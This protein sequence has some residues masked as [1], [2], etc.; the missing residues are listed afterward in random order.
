MTAAGDN[1]EER[2]A[3]EAE[4]EQKKLDIQKKYADTEMVINIAKTIAAGAL[5]IVQGFAQL[6]PVAGAVAAAIIGV[7]TAAE[8]ATIIAQRNAIKN[9][10]AGGGGG[11]APKTGSREMTGYAEGG[12]TED[13]TTVTTVGERGREW[14][15]PAWMVRKNPVT[16]SN[17]ERYRK[18]GSHGRS[19]S[20]SRGFADGGFT[21]NV[22]EKMQGGMLSVGD[23]EAA[24]ETAI[25]KSMQNGAIRAY[26]VRNDLTELDS[27]TER[28]KKMTSR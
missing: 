13:H 3:I 8:I 16:F 18:T 5:A 11:S 14:V 9:A 12:Y 25:V 10:S 7:T 27:Q 28:F 15:A 26:L 23:L 20:V 1:A 6:G 4:Y 2:E 24:V 21:E 19:G 17:L 22:S